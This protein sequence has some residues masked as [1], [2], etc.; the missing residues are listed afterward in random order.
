MRPPVPW[1]LEFVSFVTFNWSYIG[2][3]YIIIRKRFTNIF[4]LDSHSLS[5]IDIQDDT[6]ETQ[7]IQYHSAKLTKVH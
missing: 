2:L 4:G 7:A 5:V 6:R 1:L 3:R